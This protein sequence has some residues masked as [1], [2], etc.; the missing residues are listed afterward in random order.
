M[1]D[2]G[3]DLPDTRHTFYDTAG[4]AVKVNIVR[5]WRSSEYDDEE[6]TFDCSFDIIRGHEVTNL[7]IGINESKAVDIAHTLYTEDEEAT[8]SYNEIEAEYAAERR[9]GA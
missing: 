7:P 2:Y 1:H 6:T 4:E 5:H 9:L 8:N 3:F